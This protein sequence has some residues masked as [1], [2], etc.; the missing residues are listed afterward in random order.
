MRAVRTCTVSHKLATLTASFREIEGW[1][2]PLCQLAAIRSCIGILFIPGT[3]RRAINSLRLF[4]FDFFN[5]SVMFISSRGLF[6]TGRRHGIM[7]LNGFQLPPRVGRKKAHCNISNKKEAS[8]TERPSMETIPINQDTRNNRPWWFLINE[9][10]GS[11]RVAHNN[12]LWS[13]AKM[14]VATYHTMF[15]AQTSHVSSQ[16]W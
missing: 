9:K 16:S 8:E 3:V 7:S 2:G 1:A 12:T 13:N 15:L 6:G 11:L 10:E 14:K 4:W 5:A